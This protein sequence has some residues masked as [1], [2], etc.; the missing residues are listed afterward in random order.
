MADLMRYVPPA[1]HNKRTS[2]AQRVLVS[3]RLTSMMDA[4]TLTPLPH[5]WF[6]MT[7]LTTTAQNKLVD[8][9]TRANYSSPLQSK[10]TTQFPL[11][12]IW[13]FGSSYKTQWGRDSYCTG[14]N[15]LTIA[16]N[17]CSVFI[18]SHIKRN[19]FFFSP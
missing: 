6:L 3:R 16:L 4:E 17:R 15:Y 1:Q 10:V 7:T 2:C 14:F 9:L 5:P 12:I 19:P 18:S 13:Q 8:S 11:N